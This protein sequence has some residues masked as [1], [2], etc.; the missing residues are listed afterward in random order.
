MTGSCPLGRRARARLFISALI[1]DDLPSY[2]TSQMQTGQL[3]VIASVSHSSTA[4]LI[5]I[6]SFLFA[7]GVMFPSASSAISSQNDVSSLCNF[8]RQ[9]SAMSMFL[10]GT[11]TFIKH[12]PA[13]GDLLLLPIGKCPSAQCDL[14]CLRPAFDPCSFLPVTVDSMA[15]AMVMPQQADAAV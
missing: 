15:V 6:V 8:L 3:L 2:W 7:Y 1:S 11:R 9:S 13:A 14:S 12:I 5:I 4:V 10:S